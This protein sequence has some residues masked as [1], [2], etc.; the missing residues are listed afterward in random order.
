M[1]CVAIAS[2]GT[3][4]HAIDLGI[5]HPVKPAPLAQ[6]GFDRVVAPSQR[7]VFQAFLWLTSWG[8]GEH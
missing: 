4:L 2:C 8:I 5:Q 6:E 7:A 3:E 1:V